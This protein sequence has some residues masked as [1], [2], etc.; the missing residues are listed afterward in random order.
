MLEWLPNVTGG[1]YQD[2][3]IDPESLLVEVRGAN[4]WQ[5]APLLSHGTAE[6]VYL[7]LRLALSRH[8]T[9][10]DEICPL[11]LDDVVSASDAARKRVVLE[12]LLAI[13][14][15]PQVIL[16]THEDDVRDWADERLEE[17]LGRLIEVRLD[18]VTT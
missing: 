10:Q 15:S 11:I 18:P 16:F 14:E 17:P 12:T 13:S 7:L 2:C 3:R 8:L 9:K 6:Q 5:R 1:R 4:G